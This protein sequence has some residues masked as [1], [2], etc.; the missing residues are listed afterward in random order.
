MTTLEKLLKASAIKIPKD[1]QGK[2]E[3]RIESL[4]GVQY[5]DNNKKPKLDYGLGDLVKFTGTH[6]EDGTLT[7]SENVSIG[8]LVIIT[9]FDKENSAFKIAKYDTKNKLLYKEL[10]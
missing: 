1:S 8:D 7:D 10:M 2:L 6:E 4:K 3:E 9:G 5:S